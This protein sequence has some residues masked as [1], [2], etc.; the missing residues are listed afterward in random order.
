MARE[1]LFNLLQTRIDLETSR[2]ID[3]FSGTGFVA[4]E[5]CSR[6][7][8]SVLAVDQNP[9]C[10]DF[11]RKTAGLLKLDALTVLRTDV[12]RLLKS[13]QYQADLIFAD[14]PYDLATLASIPDLTLQSEILGPH[15]ILVLEHGRS[16]S[17]KEHP[18][19]VEERC[20]GKVH[21]SFF[22][23]GTGD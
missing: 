21:F 4:Y 3:L 15:G 10:A 18:S 14:P 17:F 11:I 23:K 8:L 13:A 20:Y 7:A 2:V 5:F 22:N 16:D 12:F 6:G 19:F 1:A 9:R